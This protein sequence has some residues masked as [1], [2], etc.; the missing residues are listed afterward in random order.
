MHV[1]VCV[2][3]CVCVCVCTRVYIF[4]VCVCN[5]CMCV[6]VCVCVC[7]CA[8]VCAPDVALYPSSCLG[9]RL[10]LML[11]WFTE[12]SSIRNHFVLPLSK[13]RCTSWIHSLC[14]AVEQIRKI[15]A[16]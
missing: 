1:C 2:C 14:Y 10:Y 9:M 5:V 8:C 6:C 11:P 7:V 12:G 15:I 13:L 4:I 16:D 3:N